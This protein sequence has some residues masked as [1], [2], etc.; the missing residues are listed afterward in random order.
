[1]RRLAWW[2]ILH[3][4]GYRRVR[5]LGTFGVT[6]YSSLGCESLHPLSPLPIT[7]NYGVISPTG[8]VTVRLIYDHRVIDGIAVA[9]ALAELEQELKGPI[10]DELRN[11][12]VLTR[13]RPQGEDNA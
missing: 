13:A 10:L 7:L 11:E 3:L 9:R 1:V 8:D 5:Q 6:V 2:S 4:S 12:E